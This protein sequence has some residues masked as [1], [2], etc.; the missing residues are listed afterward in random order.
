MTINQNSIKMGIVNKLLLT[1]RGWFMPEIIKNKPDQFTEEFID[2]VFI[3]DFLNNIQKLAD[4]AEEENWNYQ[5]PEFIMPDHN[6][7]ILENY[8]KYSYK[9]IKLE[10]K[11]FVSEDKKSA[12]INTG[13]LSRNNQEDIYL[14]MNENFLPD[15]NQY[16]HFGK[17]AKGS[18]KDL[19]KTFGDNLP[20]MCEYF[21]DPSEL[22]FDARKEIKIN[23]DHIIDDHFDRFPENVRQHR[24]KYE[25]R[26]LLSHATDRIKKRIK[27][28]YKIAIPQCYDGKIQFLIP[29]CLTDPL[30]TDVALVLEKIQDQSGDFIYRGNTIFT[31]D[32]A[33]NHARQIAKP[34]NEWL[35]P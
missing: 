3:P 16:W 11:I 23:Y 1:I 27:R 10:N 22:M 35:T 2:F 7:P 12:C 30:N 18:D 31:L 20:D 6:N 4:L 24:S 5:N 29:I 25:V 34:G 15:K 14:L 17:F 19:L 32:M 8:L 13:L 28:N 26:G 9:Q 33:Y 21:I